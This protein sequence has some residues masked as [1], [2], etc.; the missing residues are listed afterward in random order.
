MQGGANFTYFIYIY[1][2][3]FFKVEKTFNYTFVT[4]ESVMYCKILPPDIKG[5]VRI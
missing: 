2:Y 4:P 5:E 1:I 3:F